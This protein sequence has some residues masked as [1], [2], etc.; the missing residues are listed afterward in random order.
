M[1]YLLDTNFIINYFKG[2]F[3]GNAQH[4]TDSVV[5]GT[6]F[7]SV[8]TRIEL[9]GAKSNVEDIILINDFIS[10]S[11]LFLLDENIIQE[12]I[13]LR[14]TNKIKLPDAIIAATALVNNLQL[15]THNIK[16]FKN[17]PR[18]V[19]INANTL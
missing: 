10:D 14:K 19:V 3:E 7:I 4:F 1:D 13:S 9:L 6:T 16:D 15:I 17:V 8:I 5:N 11:V 12:T 2:I 18:L